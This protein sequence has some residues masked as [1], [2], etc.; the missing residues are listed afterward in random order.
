MVFAYPA[1]SGQDY[2][3]IEQSNGMRH[4]VMAGAQGWELVENPAYRP[5]SAATVESLLRHPP[6]SPARQ[7][8]PD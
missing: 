4:R 6:D 1:D 2:G 3:I 5:R 8:Q 7:R